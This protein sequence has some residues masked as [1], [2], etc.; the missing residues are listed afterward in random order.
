MQQ[1]VDVLKSEDEKWAGGPQSD[2]CDGNGKA[3]RLSS[4]VAVEA[5]GWNASK[6]PGRWVQST[7]LEHVRIFSR[8]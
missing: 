8:V 3:G 7:S 6:G 5:G 1:F 2:T 4:G